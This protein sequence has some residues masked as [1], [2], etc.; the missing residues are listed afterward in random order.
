MRAFSRPCWPWGF[1]EKGNATLDKSFYRNHRST[2]FKTSD[3]TDPEIRWSNHRPDQLQRFW[4]HTWQQTCCRVRSER[5][6][7][8]HKAC[9]QSGRD[10]PVW[11]TKGQLPADSVPREDDD[12]F[13]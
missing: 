1:R 6:S 8:D 2:G 4:G 10:V 13:S 5:T 12:P 11:L 3:A 9:T 7:T